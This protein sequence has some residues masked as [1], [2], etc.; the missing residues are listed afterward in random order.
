M[1][2][3]SAP[4]GAV[5]GGM[6]A[7]ILAMGIGRFGY[8]PILPLM[9]EQ[10]GVS[11]M[12]GGM[13][14][15]AN[16]LGY[17]VGSIFASNITASTTKQITLQV[18]ILLTIFSLIIFPLTNNEAIWGFLRLLSGISSGIIFVLVS[19][20]VLQILLDNKKADWLGYFYSGVGIGIALTGVVTPGL[21]NYN[22]WVGAWIGLGIIGI[23]VALPTLY[24]LQP[25]NGARQS[26]EEKIVRDNRWLWLLLA[27]T[28]EGFGYIITGT[29]L[30]SIIESIPSIKNL[31]MFSWII[32]GLAAAP[33][34][35]LW[36]YLANR[37]GN[38]SALIIAFLLQ[39]ISIIL[40]VVA[41]NSFGALLGSVLFGGTFMGITMLSVAIAGQVAPYSKT[42]AIGY[43]TTVYA[44]GQMF[45]P[46]VAGYLLDKYKSYTI[47]LT[48]A[49]IIL[50][51][52]VC[53]L[54]IGEYQKSRKG[55]ILCHTL[56]SK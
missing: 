10:V 37:L 21:N 36:A 31:A 44:L 35:F 47:A 42:K 32:V 17:F 29:F 25:I 41:A 5:I 53:S 48:F 38:M 34:T 19:S 39:I 56:I 27:Y 6:C 7:L 3:F 2:F 50:V 26:H 12:T 1:K 40:P 51:V 8:T 49:A 24:F 33:S 18:N 45:G 54:L 9:Q 30:V 20:I 13:L 55:E 15:S 46:S 52:G 14:A 22:G 28:C 23:F 11:N 4:L 16:Y 43:L